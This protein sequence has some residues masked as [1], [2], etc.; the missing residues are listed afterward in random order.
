MGLELVGSQPSYACPWTS[1][2]LLKVKDHDGIPSGMVAHLNLRHFRWVL[3]HLR[4]PYGWEEQCPFSLELSRFR[5]SFLYQAVHS[6]FVNTVVSNLKAN[7]K[8]QPAPF[9]PKFP[10]G[11][12]GLGSSPRFLLPRRCTCTPLIQLVLRLER[13]HI[14]FGQSTENKEVQVSGELTSIA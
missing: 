11:S 4:R 14:N 12:P 13:T 1:S 2:H 7:L 9:T 10:L 5:L 6:G 8:G 3:N